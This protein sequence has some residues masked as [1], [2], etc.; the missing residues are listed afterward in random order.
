MITIAY[1][2]GAV[3]ESPRKRDRKPCFRLDFSLILS[4]IASSVVMFP[5]YKRGGMLALS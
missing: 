3:K 1:A 2:V 5:I 4:G